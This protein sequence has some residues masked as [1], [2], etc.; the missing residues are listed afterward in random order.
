MKMLFTM[1]MAAVFAAFTLEAAESDY[2]SMSKLVPAKASSLAY[3]KPSAFAGHPLLK[4]LVSAA[5]APE[6]DANLLLGYGSAVAN[7]FDGAIVFADVDRNSKYGAGILQ[8]AKP[9]DLMA[10]KGLM[11]NMPVNAELGKFGDENA[12]LVSNNKEGQ[13]ESGEMAVVVMLE[14]GLFVVFLN[15]ADGKAILSDI[16]AKQGVNPE[17][18]AQISPVEDADA[19]AVVNI[20]ADATPVFERLVLSVVKIGDDGVT[21]KLH[22]VVYGDLVTDTEFAVTAHQVDAYAAKIKAWYKEMEAK[23]APESNA[24]DQSAVDNADSGDDAGAEPE[25]EEVEVVAEEE[26]K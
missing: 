13:S 15:S 26:V 1:A 14:P 18:A 17:L 11:T 20:P 2:Q 5:D 7:V 19:F 8:A 16:R 10:L 24:D 4:S 12:L 21:I 22:T 23:Y 25:T 9:M 6:E 3:A